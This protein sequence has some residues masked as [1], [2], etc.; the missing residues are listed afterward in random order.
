MI[1]GEEVMN[2]LTEVVNVVYYF[3]FYFYFLTRRYWFS[4]GGLLEA[5]WETVLAGMQPE[6]SLLV[7]TD[8]QYR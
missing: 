2:Q 1:V 5:E 7:V 8:E 4:F 6:N 3:Y